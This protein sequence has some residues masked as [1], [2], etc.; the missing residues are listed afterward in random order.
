MPSRAWS[1]VRRGSESTPGL[2]SGGVPRSEDP[3]SPQSL[4]SAES[5]LVSAGDHGDGTEERGKA[6]GGPG[7]IRGFL[8]RRRRHRGEC[9][10]DQREAGGELVAGQAGIRGSQ[11]RTG[12]APGPA[13]RASGPAGR[14]PGPTGGPAVLAGRPALLLLPGVPRR[15]WS[16][17]GLPRSRRAVPQSRPGRLPA[18]PRTGRLAAPAPRPSGPP[19]SLIAARVDRPSAGPPGMGPG[20]ARP[21]P[22]SAG[23]RAPRRPTARSPRCRWWC[24]SL[25]RIG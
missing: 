14:A 2:A 9:R 24:R 10:V 11:E 5:K 23:P 1:I 4:R 12:A 15:R 8:V 18:V 16:G 20:P 17:T 13:R 6:A 21:V 7:V 22:S 19:A 3:I 25:V